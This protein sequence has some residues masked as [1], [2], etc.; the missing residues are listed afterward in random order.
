MV[1]GNYIMQY[2]E[3]SGKKRE[4]KLKFPPRAFFNWF[5]DAEY[6]LKSCPLS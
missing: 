2:D 6:P 5:R 1:L 4:I 3:L